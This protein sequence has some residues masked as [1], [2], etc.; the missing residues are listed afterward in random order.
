MEFVAKGKEGKIYRIGKFIFKMYRSGFP[1]DKMEREYNFLKKY[2]TT[3]AVPKVYSN[4]RD[5]LDLGV[6]VMEDLKGHVTLKNIIKNKK[7]YSDEQLTA[8]LKTLVKSRYKIGYDQEYKDLHSENIMVNVPNVSGK[9]INEIN[10]R[11][12]DPGKIVDHNGAHVWIDHL[13]NLIHELR[14][15]RHP[16]SKMLASRNMR[17]IQKLL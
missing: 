14:M 15:K 16:I 11:F 17:E 13:L 7:Q 1:I 5:L 12:I 3:G 10:V 2:Q 8:L 9:K 4:K 6:I